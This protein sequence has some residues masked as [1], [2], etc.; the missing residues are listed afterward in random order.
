[1]STKISL[2]DITKKIAQEYKEETS[3][4]TD[5]FVVEMNEDSIKEIATKVFEKII[6]ALKKGEVGDVVR[7]AGFGKFE[8]VLAK[9][10]IS[11]NPRTKEKIRVP[12][13]KRVKFRKFSS[14]REI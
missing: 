13:K 11:T 12:A 2:R 7:I 10:R 1:M 3:D 6:S 5:A 14:L 4:E 9:E 8:I